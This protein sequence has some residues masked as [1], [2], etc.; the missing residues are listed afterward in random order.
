MWKLKRDFADEKR[1]V[2]YARKHRAEYLACFANLE[3][4][5]AALNAGFT[6]QHCT[7]G[8]FSG[9]GMDVY[10]IGQT[11][12]PHAHETRLYIYAEIVGKE[13]QLL[14][15]GDKKSQKHDINLCHTRVQEIRKTKKPDGQGNG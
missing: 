10:R 5:Q 9:E 14:T 8:F 1:F 13:I 6:L 11:G 2:R 12:V 7:F 4:L 3:R 15:I